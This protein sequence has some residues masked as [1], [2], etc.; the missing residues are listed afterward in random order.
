MGRE[1]IN[2][3]R[4]GERER[5]ESCPRI[6]PCTCSLGNGGGGDIIAVSM[7][8]EPKWETLTKETFHHST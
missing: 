1:K 7:K 8:Q 4:G 6:L 5:K 2:F 3:R